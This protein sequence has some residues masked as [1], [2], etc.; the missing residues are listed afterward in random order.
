MGM[1]QNHDIRIKCTYEELIK[2]KKNAEK[3]GM[4][5]RQYMLYVA[6]NTEVNISIKSRE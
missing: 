5:I 3:L 6:L 2:I 4:T 1:R